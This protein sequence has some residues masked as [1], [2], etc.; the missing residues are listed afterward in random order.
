[1]RNPSYLASKDPVP[2]LC[3]FAAED[4]LAF[5]QQLRVPQVVVSSDKEL[6]YY[7]NDHL[8][9]LQY[10]SQLSGISHVEMAAAP[11]RSSL[12]LQLCTTQSLYAS[13][14]I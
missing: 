1:M 9:A 14:H 4:W 6:H 10:P 12:V 13:H 7:N 11:L 2:E 3:R 8:F 5:P